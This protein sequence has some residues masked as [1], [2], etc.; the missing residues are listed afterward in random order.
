M[1]P[2]TQLTGIGAKRSGFALFLALTLMSF[3][4]VLILS[5]SLLINVETRSASTG[6]DQLRAKESARLALMIALGELQKH[7]GPD[8]RVT[9]RA[10][11]LGDGNYEP[12]AKFWTGVW[13]T[14]DP[15]AD[16]VWLV[17]GDEPDP[18]DGSFLPTMELV[19]HSSVGAETSQHI[20]APIVEVT[21][22]D[23]N[24]KT[25][26]A[27]WISDEGVKLSVGGKPQNL[28]AEPN[29]LEQ[30]AMDNLDTML[31]VDPGLESIF[32]QYDRYTST[33]AS[34]LELITSLSQLFAVTSFITTEETLLSDEA[35]Y[36]AL[37]PMSLGVLANV[38][39]DANGGLMQDIS[40]FPRLIS[41]SFEN[42]M[43]K[44]E[45][46]AKERSEIGD[47][48]ISKRHFAELLGLDQVAA[49]SDGDIVEQ[50]TPIMTNFMMAF[51]VRSESPVASNPNFY[52][53]M[54]F[55][56]EFWNPYTSI[57]KM[58]NPNL[59][60]LDLE[61]EIEGLPEIT[62]SKTKG[63]GVSAPINIQN[64][65][66]DPK[67]VNDAVVLRLKYDHDYDW[68]P[69]QTKNW[70]GVNS[71]T[72]TETSLNT[73]I[74]ASPYRAVMTES[75]DWDDSDNTLGGSTG[76]NTGEPR[77]S[78]DIRHTSTGTTKL[79]I[80]I[81]AIHEETDYKELLTELTGIPY[82]PVSTR[83]KGYSSTHSGSTFGYHFILRG[84]H[85]SSADPEYYRGLWLK[86]HDPR[87]PR[88]SFNEDWN[89]DN[90]PDSDTG[91]AYV[92]V[93]DGISPLLL[94]DPSEINETN[95]T[96]NTV[97]FRRFMDRSRGK[98]TDEF[99]R[100]WQ[101]APLF[102][103]PQDRVLSLGTLQH[104]YFHNERPNKVGNSWGADGAVNTLSWFDRYY[105]SGFSR[106]DD[107]ENINLNTDLPNP[108]LMAYDPSRIST[109]LVQAQETSS[110]DIDASTKLAEHLLTK[111]RF[112]LNS[113]SV[114]AWKGILGGLRHDTLDYLDYSDD[115]ARNS[116]YLTVSKYDIET[117]IAELR[118]AMFSRYPQSLVQTYDAPETP[119][120]IN[121]ESVAP[122][123]FYRR[124][125]RYFD[126]TEIEDFAT[127]VVRLIKERGEP[128]YSME[129]FLSADEF[130]DQSLLEKAIRNIFSEDGLQKWDHEWETKGTR[131]LRSDQIDIDHFSPG[132]LTQADVISA[133]GPM[134]APRS[135]TFRI[136]ARCIN[137]DVFGKISGSAT[138]EAT[139]QRI[140]EPVSTSSI[141]IKESNKRKFEL[142]DIRWIDE[143]KL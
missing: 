136:R 142:V 70:T 49:F 76:I 124:G 87:N 113:T 94:P 23:S 134:L 105:F 52:L 5:I 82:E 78:G 19:G 81:Y 112:N 132:F 106:A 71:S 129:E 9:A 38:L 92:P 91:S 118:T 98:G 47:D 79:T 18:T 85:L 25:E 33:D 140:P 93:K 24:T 135:D 14:T 125:A 95:S 115:E 143:A 103:I 57:L 111:N 39:P 80:R 2:P 107:P 32:T 127:E 130:D 89:L 1:K 28:E 3:I 83:I 43:L 62:M 48:L 60:N 123:A 96:I 35:A 41:D 36:H 11:I 54:R 31:T 13:N 139:Y 21:D 109:G 7:A 17:S 22:P 6:L 61:L 37:T 10:D 117:E 40:L 15:S 121:N 133:I 64:L 29:F 100:L 27:W 138:V 50:V 67:N 84:P 90:H 68:L 58:N 74:G 34:D 56:T 97:I 116:S 44:A 126:S 128:F 20:Y 53:R 26:I 65:L 88:P 46:S 141:P 114:V 108:T 55:F 16:P 131:G 4:V 86:D 99:N 51:T 104:L 59:G 137:Y 120:F 110:D 12:N 63:S 8:Q 69:G 102:E 119:Q 77:L 66:K 72:A 122:S 101:D 42:I 45:N 75:K 30:T 73:A